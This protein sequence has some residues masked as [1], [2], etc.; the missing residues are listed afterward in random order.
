MTNPGVVLVTGGSRG[1]GEAIACA[2]ASRGWHVAIT[3]RERG[4]EAQRVLARIESYGVRSCAIAGDVAEEAD[5]L[6]AFDAAQALGPLRALVNN[7]GITAGVARVADA[8]RAQF[9][10][11]FRT[12]VLGTMLCAREAVRRMSTA[13]GGAGGAIVNI[14]SGAARTGSP[15]TWVH[16]AATKGAVDTFTIGLAR[17][18]AGEGVRVN[19]VRAGPTHTELSGSDPQRTARLAAAVPMLRIAEPAEIAAAVMWLLDPAGSYVTGALLD[20]TGGL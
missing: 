20:A 7:A 19:A 15:G 1:I 4:A 6:R 3:Y 5:V 12:N 16:Y 17:E 9:E 14:S 18:V 10:S 13:R 8:T 2:A 11:V